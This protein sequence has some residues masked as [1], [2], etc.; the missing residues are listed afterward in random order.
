MAFDPGVRTGWA[1]YTANVIEGL[2]SLNIPQTKS[3]AD[4]S[5]DI[6]FI[7][8]TIRTEGDE[9]IDELYAH[10]DRWRTHDM[11]VIIE[12]FQNRMR[13]EW[14]ELISLYYEGALVGWCKAN[15]VPYTIQTPS[16]GKAFWDDKKLA[17]CGL[18]SR[19]LKQNKDANDAM[20]HLCKWLTGN[21]RGA[22]TYLLG[23]LR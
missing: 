6:K 13:L 10:L 17:A 19:P 12:H 16:E 15:E 11:H 5:Y 22:K 4:E 18:L 9:Q 21:D 3:M 2:D 8:G 20:R 1:M 7:S 23:K 14:N